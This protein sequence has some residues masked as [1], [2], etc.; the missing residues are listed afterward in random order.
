ML[1]CARE[2]TSAGKADIRVN[3]ETLSGL[4]QH[5]LS[6]RACRLRYSY[7]QWTRKFFL[8]KERCPRYD[9]ASPYLRQDHLSDDQSMRAT[10]RFALTEHFKLSDTNWTMPRH[11][12]STPRQTNR[13][14]KRLCATVPGL[15]HSKTNR[16]N[17]LPET[18]RRRQLSRSSSFRKGPAT[19]KAGRRV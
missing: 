8:S 2:T 14:T 9:T 18:P 10:L 7:K 16:R 15:P 12:P 1:Q 13:R 19:S 4:S 11:K 5:W 3:S 6:L 17:G